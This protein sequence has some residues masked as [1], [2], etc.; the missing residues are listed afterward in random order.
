MDDS[1]SARQ[2]VINA[3]AAGRKISRMGRLLEAGAMFGGKG[4]KRT[5]L[6]GL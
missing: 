1:A 5:R 6:N 3:K 2:A 4:A